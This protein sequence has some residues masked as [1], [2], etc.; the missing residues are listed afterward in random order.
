M[1]S[2]YKILITILIN[3]CILNIFILDF[4][5]ELNNISLAVYQLSVHF[6]VINNSNFLQNNELLHKNIIKCNLNCEEQ[7][8]NIKDFYNYKSQFK[9][10]YTMIPIKITK[11]SNNECRL[12]FYTKPYISNINSNP[13]NM[14][15][16]I[17][18]FKLE[19]YYKY[20]CVWYISDMTSS[21]WK[22]ND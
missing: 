7:I 8:A 15:K 5:K 9:H 21:L 3:L 10:L 19:Y 2:I 1:H 18:I 20:K 22:N 12:L 14:F 13:T 4:I 6:Q 11:I 16:D 17:R